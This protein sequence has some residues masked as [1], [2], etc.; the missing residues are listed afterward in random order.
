V[1]LVRTGVVTIAKLKDIRSYV[2]VGAFVVAAVVT[3]PDVVSQLLLAIPMCL[4][5]EFGILLA[6]LIERFFR[7]HVT[8]GASTSDTIERGAAE[9]EGPRGAAEAEQKRLK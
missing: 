6:Q 8:E 2:I 4:L 1:V 3:P 7:K 5:Y 9:L